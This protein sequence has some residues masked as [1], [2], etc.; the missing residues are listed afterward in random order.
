MG[1]GTPRDVVS[2]VV[3]G[4]APVVIVTTLPLDELPELPDGWVAK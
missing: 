3:T 1:P 4:D 2:G